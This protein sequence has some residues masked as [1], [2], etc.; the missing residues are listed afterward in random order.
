[1]L[2]FFDF[3]GKKLEKNLGNERREHRNKGTTGRGNEGTIGMKL[4]QPYS[5]TWLEQGFFQFKLGKG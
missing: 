2:E 3:E 4:R 1:M 5:K